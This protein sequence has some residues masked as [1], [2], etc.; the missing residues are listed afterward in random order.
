MLWNSLL[1]VSVVMKD[2]IENA[3]SADW[4]EKRLDQCK[5]QGAVC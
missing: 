4:G 3:V 1:C 2:E 5:I